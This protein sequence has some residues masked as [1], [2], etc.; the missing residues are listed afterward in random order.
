MNNLKSTN[1][2][3]YEFLSVS[4]K[5][6]ASCYEAVKLS[7][8]H[9]NMFLFQLTLPVYYPCHKPIHVCTKILCDKAEFHKLCIPED[10]HFKVMRTRMLSILESR[11]SVKAASEEAG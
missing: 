7:F 9:T 3:D 1:I 2:S 10:M 11:R 4:L 8:K 6:S 5:Y